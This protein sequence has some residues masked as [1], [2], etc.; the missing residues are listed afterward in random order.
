M[1]RE[2]ESLRY[3]WGND[4]VE[5]ADSMALRGDALLRRQCALGCHAALRT[6][7]QG[8]VLVSIRS[9]PGGSARTRSFMM[10]DMDSMYKMF[11]VF[12]SP[13][14]DCLS[15]L[16]TRSLHFSVFCLSF[17]TETN[18]CDAS[19][20]GTLTLLSAILQRGL[21]LG[22]PRSLFLIHPSCAL[23]EP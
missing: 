6:T 7:T 21:Q 23:P 4:W 3:A 12:I 22:T 17:P 8:V 15:W 20:F 9:R 5:T 14:D 18:H 2:A 11:C 10:V 1:A 13:N 16:R 19:D